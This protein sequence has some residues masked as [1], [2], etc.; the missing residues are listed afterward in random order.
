MKKLF[1]NLIVKKLFNNLIFKLVLGVI[2]GIIIGTYSS[3]GL[4]STIV[5]IKYVLGQIIFFSVPLIILGFI[6]PSIAK[7]KDNASKLLGYAV[8]SMIA[9]YALIPKLSIVS[10]IASLKELPELIFKLDIPPVMSVMSAL[11]LALLLGLAVG[12]TKADLVEKLL[13]QFQAIVLSIVNKII[14]PILPFF[15]ATNFAALAYE[16]GL[17]N[18]L[19][20]FFKVILIVLFGHF[21]W[22]TILYLIGGAISKENPWEVVKYYGPA[23][24]TAVGTMSSAATLPV[25][26]ES[27]K[28]SKA[29]RE[30]IVDFAIPLCSNIHLCGSVLTEVFFVMT[31]SQILYGK[32]PSLPTMILF[33]LLL[34]VFAIGAPGVRGV[35]KQL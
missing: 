4:M 19:P 18:Q 23:Y 35:F 24:L 15:I 5:T 1:N 9:G 28:K 13:D 14:I 11:A 20:V 31:V 33:I 22:L 34:G 32:I 7:L 12:W 21:I 30:D 29:L 27:A 17:S 26:L 6:A 8:L 2:L 3:E 25:A 10:N 16:G